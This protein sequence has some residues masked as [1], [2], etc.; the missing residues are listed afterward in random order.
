VPLY[1]RLTRLA[2]QV[3]LEE[4]KLSAAELAKILDPVTM[5]EPKPRSKL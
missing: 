4:T 3:A 2:T 5:V 1:T